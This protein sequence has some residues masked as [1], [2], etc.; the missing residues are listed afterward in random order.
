MQSHEN[1]CWGF[2]DLGIHHSSNLR[3]LLKIDPKL[4]VVMVSGC[5]SASALDD[6]MKLG[7][8]GFVHKPYDLGAL[9]SA[10][11]RVLDSP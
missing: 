8:S 9:L 3:E 10:I 4:R 7:A 6:T 11:R 5:A 2:I 1:P